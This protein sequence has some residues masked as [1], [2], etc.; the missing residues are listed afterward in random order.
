M[1]V[2]EI[3]ICLQPGDRGEFMGYTTG[4]REKIIEFLSKNANASYSL[5]DICLSIL[6]TCL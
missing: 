1:S 5:E 2:M 3:K 4:K 6:A